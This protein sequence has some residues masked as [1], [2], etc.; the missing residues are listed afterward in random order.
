MNENT[1]TLSKEGFIHLLMLCNILLD[2][3]RAEP[4]TVVRRGVQH[5]RGID[6][7]RVNF[8]KW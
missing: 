5:H 7:D 1:Q 2:G 8:M 4:D 3:V 6:V